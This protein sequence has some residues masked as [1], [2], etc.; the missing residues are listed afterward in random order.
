M[1]VNRVAHK[2][3]APQVGELVAR[4]RELVLDQGADGRPET[5]GAAQ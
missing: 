3:L 1:I 2:M 4:L 5:P